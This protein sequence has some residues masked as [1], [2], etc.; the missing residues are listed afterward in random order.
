MEVYIQN[1]SLNLLIGFKPESDIFV[2]K[3]NDFFCVTGK[4]MLYKQTNLLYS[5]KQPLLTHILFSNH[6]YIALVILFEIFDHSMWEV[7]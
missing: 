7:F 2:Y 1:A 4:D 5:E 3:T 6:E